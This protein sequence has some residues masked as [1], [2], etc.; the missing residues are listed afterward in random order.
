MK[1][2]DKRIALFDMDGTLCD[3]SLVLK[4]DLEKLRCP[5]ESRVKESFGKNIPR[6]ME[7]RMNLIKSSENWWTNLPK[8]KLGWDILNIAKKMNFRIVILSKGPK[9]NPEAYTGKKR[10]IE[11]HLGMDT[12]V[13]LTPDKGLVYG[14]ILVDDYPKFILDW[15]KHRPHGLA[16]MPANNENKNFKHP[17]VIRYDGKNLAKVKAAIKQAKAIPFGP[18]N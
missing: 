10:W 4:R 11:K 9:N 3:Y 1:E 12:D 8:F 16:I 7:E 17:Q 14:R 13:I 15:L 6:Y 2:S 5:H 18:V